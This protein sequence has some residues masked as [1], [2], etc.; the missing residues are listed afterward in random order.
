MKR[1]KKQTNEEVSVNVHVK[2]PPLGERSIDEFENMK[3]IISDFDIPTKLRILLKSKNSQFKSDFNNRALYAIEAFI[4]AH[5][6]G[7]YPPLW[8]L[9]Y[10]ASVLE[11]FHD[12]QGK[13]SLDQCFGFKRGRGQKGRGS[14][15]LFKKAAEGERDRFLAID[16]Y[17][18]KVLFGISVKKG[19]EMVCR[20]LEET[21]S[22]VDL[23]IPSSETIEYLYI[24]KYKKI[25]FE[26][27]NLIGSG[28]TIKD[29]LSKWTDRQKQ[30]F[31]KS[32]PI[33]S[34]P[35]NLRKYL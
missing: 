28:L 16:I 23:R 11:D 3:L 17:R 6:E 15:P 4:I 25:L 10:I 18:L 2:H 8:A 34:I 32:F 24:K 19:A 35:N 31:L 20:R 22:E 27:E 7:I 13:K 26:N 14:T 9:N 30:D 33:D 29:E 5:H 21:P 12:A 1:R